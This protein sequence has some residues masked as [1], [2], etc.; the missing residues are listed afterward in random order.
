MANTTLTGLRLYADKLN[1]SVDK[2]VDKASVCDLKFIS[3]DII[4]INDFIRELQ[5]SDIY[6]GLDPNISKKFREA[7][8]KYE[9]HKEILENDC[10]CATK[11]QIGMLKKK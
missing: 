3:D 7:K 9:L 8:A 4:T 2:F 10:I 5:R 1:E 11:K 6:V